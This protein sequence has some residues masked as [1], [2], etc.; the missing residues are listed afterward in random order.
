VKDSLLVLKGYLGIR[1]QEGGKECMGCLAL[2]APYPLDAKEQEAGRKLHRSGIMTMADQTSLFSAGAFHHVD[3]E[4]I[5]HLVIKIL[6][7][8]VA[9]FKGNRYHCLVG[10]RKS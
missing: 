10:M 5:D 2:P 8:T 9:I 3:L 1:N 6:R 4:V 7:K